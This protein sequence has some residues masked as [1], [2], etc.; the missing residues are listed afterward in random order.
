MIQMPNAD[1][2]VTGG[3]GVRAVAPRNLVVSG[4]LARSGELDRGCDVESP[5][6]EDFPTGLEDSRQTD[7]RIAVSGG[8]GRLVALGTRQKSSVDALGKCRDVSVICGREG[9]DDDVTAVQ[10]E[11]ARRLRKTGGWS[12]AAELHQHRRIIVVDGE[13]RRTLGPGQRSWVESYT[14]LRRVG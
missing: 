2:R 11:P 13:E 3:R 9:V 12:S 7:L 10:G 14:R 4:H 1:A 5:L 6:L 8:D